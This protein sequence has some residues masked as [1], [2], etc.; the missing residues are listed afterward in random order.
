MEESERNTAVTPLTKERVRAAIENGEV[1]YV[2]YNKGTQ[3]GRKRPLA[4]TSVHGE[5]FYARDMTAGRLKTFHF[6]HALECDESHP[7][8]NYT[9]R[10][11]TTLIRDPVEHF[12]RWAYS[13]EKAH[14]AALGVALREFIDKDKTAAARDA[15]RAAGHD[16]DYV[17][18]IAY[19]HLAYADAGVD[20]TEFNEGDLFH[21]K[22]EKRAIQVVKLADLIE[23]HEIILGQAPRR[24]AYRVTADDLA[25]WLRDGNAPSHARIPPMQS[26]ASALFRYLS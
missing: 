13:I 10:A 25:S 16:D 9:R 2:I 26:C 23:V 11:R 17:K 21:H 19:R 24:H 15:A 22:S 5:L 4:P 3:P 7:A 6:A 14:W 1:I 18:R 8:A 20:R 12:A